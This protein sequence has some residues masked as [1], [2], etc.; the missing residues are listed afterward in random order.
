MPS[1][2]NQNLTG[3]DRA[4]MTSSYPA[5]VV[6]L[7]VGREPNSLKS[8]LPKPGTLVEVKSGH[9]GNDLVTLGFTDDREEE[10]KIP[11]GTHALVVG[12]WTRPWDKDEP[13]PLISCEY[14]VGWL[15][16]DEIKVIDAKI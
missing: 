11:I 16:P 8:K 14:G 6:S 4:T 12:E 9:L 13:M 5:P 2:L 3:V 10:I 1:S 7:T 15:F